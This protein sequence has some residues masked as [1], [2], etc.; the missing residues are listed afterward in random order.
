MGRLAAPYSNMDGRKASPMQRSMHSP[1]LRATPLA[2]TGKRGLVS[3]PSCPPGREGGWGGVR[4][5]VKDSRAAGACRLRVTFPFAHSHGVAH[6]P[7][8]LCL[9]DALS[10]FWN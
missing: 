7:F 2:Q 1:A 4:L 10:M 8:S 3:P 6:D 5:D 9:S